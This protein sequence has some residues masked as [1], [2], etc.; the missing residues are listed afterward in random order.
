MPS[1]LDTRAAALW[2]RLL[3][4]FDAHA[5]ETLQLNPPATEEALD[6]LAFKIGHAAPAELRA[7]Y[8]VHDGG[9]A[10]VLPGG[11]WFR[12]LDE[13][14]ADWAIFAALADKFFVD[15]P[16]ERDLTGAHWDAP[17]H[18]N[19]IPF[20]TREDFDL[21]IDLDPGKRGAPGQILYPLHESS[22]TV[23]GGSLFAFLERWTAL[24]DSDAI[25]WSEAHCHPIAVGDKDYVELLSTRR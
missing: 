14:A 3:R 25:A 12:S 9:R 18:R 13:I 1:P 21:W 11:A 5:P 23:V 8:R 10:R 7:L 2:G 24:L 17:C 16:V 19:W 6:R 20:A 4:P 15:A 22:V